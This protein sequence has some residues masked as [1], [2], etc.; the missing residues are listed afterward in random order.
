MTT[1]LAKIGVIDILFWVGGGFMSPNVVWYML[2]PSI[3]LVPG[4]AANLEL[5]KADSHAHIVMSRTPC[6]DAPHNLEWARAG[7]DV[8]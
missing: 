4:L 6:P 8:F 7:K 2:P 1:Q 5:H 3:R